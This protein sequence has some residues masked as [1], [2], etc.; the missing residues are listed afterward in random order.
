[1]NKALLYSYQGAFIKKYY[2]QDD[3]MHKAEM[4]RA[5]INPNKLKLDYDDKIL[6]VG[7]EHEFQAGDIIEWVDTNTYWLICLQQTTEVA[8]FRGEIRKCRY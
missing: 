3:E 4:V 1:M 2:P 6:S 8:Y 7:F 5:L